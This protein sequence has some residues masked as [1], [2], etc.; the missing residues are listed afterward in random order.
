MEKDSF[1]QLADELSRWQDAGLKCR[2]WWRDDDLIAVS[3]GLHRI[4]QVSERH[5]VY[6]LV[7]IIPHLM[8]STLGQ[9]T[10]GMN[11]FVWCQHGF[12]HINHESPDRPNSEF[13]LNREKELVLEDLVKGRELLLQQFSDRLFPVLVPPWNGFRADMLEELPALGLV[14]ISQYGNIARQQIGQT[15][16]IDTHL[17]VVDWTS[18]PRFLPTRISFL[19][20]RL[21]ESLQ[22]RRLDQGLSN[23]VTGILTH[24]RAMDDE[25]WDFVERLLFITHQFP[26]V[27][28][29]SPRDLFRL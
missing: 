27:E 14:G 16:R 11:T 10:I 23:N 15:L 20:D 26:C 18:A 3:P 28:W 9:D 24:H 5:V 4:R 1:G 29:I 25:A 13:P 8:V 7:G 22:I 12:A 6:V 2:F 17:D 19:L 21:V